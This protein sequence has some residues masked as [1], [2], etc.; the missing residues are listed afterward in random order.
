M[1][2]FHRLVDCSGGRNTRKKPQ[3]IK[4]DSENEPNGLI[5][6]V[7]LPVIGEIPRDLDGVYLR[8]GPNP[9]F[10]PVGR[11]H[12]FDGDGMVHAVENTGKTEI[13]MLLVETKEPAKAPPAA[14]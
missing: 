14:K 5:E 12:W 10:P 3:L 7:N 11:Y 6:A 9:Q 4:T 13:K 1:D 8:N 2:Q